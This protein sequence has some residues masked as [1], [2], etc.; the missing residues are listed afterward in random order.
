MSENANRYNANENRAYPIDDAATAV[1]DAGGFLPH[2]IVVDATVAFPASLG[3]AA[4]VV[5]V[6]AGP[7][8]VTVVVASDARPMVPLGAV[9][10]AAPVVAYRSYAL[11]PLREGVAGWLV[12]GQG[13]A[14]AR[15]YSGRF[16]DPAQGRLLARCCRAYRDL[17]VET[18]GKEGRATTLRGL[19]GLRAGS[20]VAIAAEVVTIDG[21]DHDAITIGLAPRPGRDVFAAYSGPCAGRPEQGSCAKVGLQSINRVVP[22]CDGNIDIDFRMIAARAAPGGGGLLLALPVGMAQACGRRA[23]PS[24]DGATPGVAAGR[25]D[26]IDSS[27]GG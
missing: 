24:S 2:D 9:T 12:F 26:S 1:D 10:V 5:A 4:C 11:A 20:D 15:S 7:G 14:G 21:V 23:L 8:V 6:T 18:I 16:S 19:V 3:A 22:D 13:G 17:P 27:Y 25:C